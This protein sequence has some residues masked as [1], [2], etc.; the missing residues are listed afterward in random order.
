MPHFKSRRCVRR[1]SL[2]RRPVAAPGRSQVPAVRGR[3]VAIFFLL[4]YNGKH[5]SALLATIDLKHCQRP[6]DTLLRQTKTTPSGAQPLSRKEADQTD[7]GEIITFRCLRKR[8]VITTP[9][10]SFSS[11]CLGINCTAM[12]GSSSSTTSSVSG[13]CGWLQC[14]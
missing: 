14:L 7:H 12:I 4:R 3:S 11:S 9:F 8:D 5:K 6:A 2:V 13:E 10:S 1:P